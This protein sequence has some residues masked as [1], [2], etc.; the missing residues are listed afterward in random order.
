M[1]AEL[2]QQAAVRPWPRHAQVVNE[3]ALRTKPQCVIC[4]RIAT[5][6]F[7]VNGYLFFDC[8]ACDYA[9]L[10][11]VVAFLAS[12]ETIFGDEYFCGGGAGYPNYFDEAD[13][14]R[15]HGTR[16]GR[17]L[18]RVG[19]RRVLDVGAAAGFIMHGMIQAGC[20]AVGIEPN[21]SMAAYAVRELGLDVRATTLERFGSGDQFDAV[22]MLQVVDHVEDIRLSFERVRALTRAGGWCLIEFG[23]RA[24]WTARI[25]GSSWHEY[26]PP[27]VQRVF[28]L[29][30]LRLLLADYGFALHTCGRPAKYLRADHALS[31]LQYKAGLPIAKAAFGRLAS[32][33]P[34]RAKLRY[35]GDDITWA[36]FEKSSIRAHDRTGPER[37]SF[38]AHRGAL[39]DSPIG[40]GSMSTPIDAFFKPR[41]AAVSARPSGRQAPV[42]RCSSTS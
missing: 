37:R 40:M 21:V 4:A 19:V 1:S 28:S 22:A 20:G 2:T 38:R 41:S 26:A 23:N 29:R 24:S 5:S 11:P 6:S 33:I 9:F 7:I 12:G 39:K 31:L 30:A 18:A 27:S 14:L 25:L 17:L 42:V 15:S 3:L 36:L 8:A 35:I 16:Y 10:D 34:A 32:A 13:L